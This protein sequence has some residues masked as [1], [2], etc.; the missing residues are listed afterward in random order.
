[1]DSESGELVKLM[2]GLDLDPDSMPSYKHDPEICN[3]W[4]MAKDSTGN[5]PQ[6]YQDILHQ[7]DDNDGPF[8]DLLFNTMATIASNSYGTIR[9]KDNSKN[10]TFMNWVVVGEDFTP[11]KDENGNVMQFLGGAID[12]TQYAQYA[13][14]HTAFG[15]ADTDIHVLRLMPVWKQVNNPFTYNVVLNWVDNLGNIHAEDF[16]DY[17]D[18]VVTEMTAGEQVYVFLNKDAKPL[19]DWIANHPTYTFWDGVNNATNNDE[20]REALEAY[21]KGGHNNYDN[22]FNALTQEDFIVD[23]EEYKGNKT[24]VRLSNDIFIVTED[25][26][27]IS[28]WMYENKGGLIFHKDVQE[29]P[30]TADDEFYFT[31]TKAKVGAG[32]KALLD[33]EYKAYP[34]FVYDEDGNPR[35]RTDD[36]AWL[37]KFENGEIVSINGDTEVTYFTLKSGEGIALYV[38]NGQYTIAELGSKSGGAYKVSVEYDGDKTDDEMDNWDIPDNED[39]WVIG[40]SQIY[41]DPES[42]D[43]SDGISQVSATVNFEIGEANLVHTLIFTNSTLSMRINCKVLAP[44]GNA[45]WNYNFRYQLQF[46]LPAGETPPQDDEGNYYYNV[47]AYR[48]TVDA[49]GNIKHV[50]TSGKLQ[51]LP[52]TQADTS[53]LG[54]FISLFAAGDNVWYGALDSSNSAFTLKDDD[55]Y[56]IVLPAPSD[57]ESTISYKATEA[58]PTDSETWYLDGEEYSRSGEL[59]LGVQAEETYVNTVN[60]PSIYVTK[61]VVRSD[62]KQDNNSFTFTVT[63]SDTTYTDA[64]FTN[65]V[66]TFTL[67]DGD[68]KYLVLEDIS[69]AGDVTYTVTETAND[70]YTTTSTNASGTII[71]GSMIYVSF[72]NTLITPDPSYLVITETGGNPSETF[73]YKITYKTTDGEEG[74]LIVSVKG[75]GSTTINVPPGDYVIEELPDWSWRYE[76]EKTVGDAPQD[77]WTISSDWITAKRTIES[78]EKKEV[79]YYH[80]LNDKAWLGGESSK[81]NVFVFSQSKEN[82]RITLSPSLWYAEIKDFLSQIL[83]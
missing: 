2:D 3:L 59:E 79:T 20:I 17:W 7:Y 78:A 32:Y 1:M 6:E 53:A 21:L 82:K 35:E 28:I 58:K 65:G 42:S 66:A 34:E 15:S 13:V 61:R 43:L 44:A 36:D 50:A 77:E 38:P 48:K 76:N 70:E 47:T 12:F 67:K 52:E 5:V 30:F 24:F 73:L 63:L 68:S 19:L 25:G 64:N 81:N 39:L 23:G 27:T 11:V 46:T 71:D 72:V 75:G 40:N 56:V 31:A 41:Y 10:Y 37:V 49:D 9:P 8:Y 18:E 54:N 26:G 14:K 69:T 33:G 22:I 51:M 83:H 45:L 55:Y 57:S 4:Q 60:D 16:S 62:G 80:K 74:E 29:E